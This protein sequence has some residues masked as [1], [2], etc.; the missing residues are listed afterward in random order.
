MVDI[1]S[2]YK[3]LHTEKSKSQP[4]KAERLEGEFTIL[5]A[6][7]ISMNMLLLKTL[8]N[9]ILDKVNVIECSNGKIAVENYRKHDIDLI[10]MDVQMPEMDGLTA[11]KA[12]RVFETKSGKSVPIVALTAGALKEEQMKCYEAGMDD[13]LTKPI[14]PEALKSTL[15][16]HLLQKDT[17]TLQSTETSALVSFNKPRLLQLIDNHLP[18]LKEL[19]I[20][21]RDLS[22]KILE[23][24]IMLDQGDREGIKANA[25]YTRGAS[26]SMEFEILASIFE[27]M[28]LTSSKAEIQELAKLWENL[29]KEWATLI[30]IIEKEIQDLSD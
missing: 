18:L 23:I 9:N 30:Q 19:L 15:E 17:E 10:F 2:D 6:E 8:L 25:H 11:T 26:Q 22:E 28:E 20:T 13:F 21:S 1:L 27:T 14:Q 16:K 12:I 4:E 29:D 7:D 24:K 3:A 5:V